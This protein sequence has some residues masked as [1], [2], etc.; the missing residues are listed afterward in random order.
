MPDFSLGTY[1]LTTRQKKPKPWPRE[2]ARSLQG[3]VVGLIFDLVFCF[4]DMP[5]KNYSLL[6]PW[7]YLNKSSPVSW[8]Y[9]PCNALRTLDS[10]ILW[11][12]SSGGALHQTSLGRV[13]CFARWSSF[14][15]PWRW[16]CNCKAGREMR[17]GYRM[18]RR[19]LERIQQDLEKY[20]EA[21]ILLWWTSKTLLWR[22]SKTLFSR[23]SKP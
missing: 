8:C 10:N 17:M 1:T 22:T 12:G 7:T 20:L 3:S 15:N 11:L 13:K 21:Q 18:L 19:E 16:T 6:I 5:S 9:A 2:P 14:G 4:V 23:A